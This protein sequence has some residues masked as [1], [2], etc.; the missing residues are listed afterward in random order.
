MQSRRFQ[1]PVNAEII[2]NFSQFSFTDFNFHFHKPI[3]VHTFNWLKKLNLELKLFAQQLGYG[4]RECRV[5][6]ALIQA[7][8]CLVA[9]AH[10]IGQHGTVEGLLGRQLDCRKNRW[11]LPRSFNSLRWTSGNWRAVPVTFD[12]KS[13]EKF[14]M[15][16]TPTGSWIRSRILTR[17]NPTAPSGSKHIEFFQNFK[18][19]SAGTVRHFDG[20]R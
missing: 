1:L 2:S 12:L 11:N 6:C 13:S 20:F 5:R 18:V 17:S 3:S 19:E 14:K 16:S 9:L 10:L 8:R 4:R 15:F 7:E